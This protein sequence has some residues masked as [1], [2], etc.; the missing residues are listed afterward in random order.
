MPRSVALFEASGFEIVPW[1]VDYQTTGAESF[2]LTLADASGRLA[3]TATAMREWIGL[4]AYWAS[5][6]ISSPF[7]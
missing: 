5:G 6:K 7:P 2:S 4:F 3:A 1:P